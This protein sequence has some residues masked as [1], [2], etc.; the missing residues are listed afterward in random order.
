MPSSVP[1]NYRVLFVC[2]GNICRSPT[3]EAVFRKLVAE[4]PL[5]GKM[6]IDSAGTIGF[7]A[8]AKPDRRAIAHGASRG[9]DLERLRARQVAEADFARFDY[10]IAMDTQNVLHLKAVCPP[11]QAHKIQL[12]MAYAP[13]V[14]NHEVPDPYYGSA[15]DFEHALALIECGCKGLLRHIAHRH[16]SGTAIVQERAR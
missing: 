9:Y 7:H 8:G 16:V 2:M 13:D 6:E 10:V 5:A 14:G 12:L 11:E 1:V 4:S 3:A 15:A